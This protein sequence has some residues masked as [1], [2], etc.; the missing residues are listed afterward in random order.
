[1]FFRDFAQN[2]TH[3]FYNVGKSAAAAQYLRVS[4]SGLKAGANRYD[5]LTFGAKNIVDK[6]K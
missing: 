6:T 2:R 1:M 5:F 4:L 3:F